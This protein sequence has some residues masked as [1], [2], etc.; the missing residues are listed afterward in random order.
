MVPRNKE[1]EI[2]EAFEEAE[3][4]HHHMMHILH[5][6]LRF[7][8]LM[9][10]ALGLFS[11]AGLVWT[12]GLMTIVHSTPTAVKNDSSRYTCSFLTDLTMYGSGYA[13]MALSVFEPV[14]SGVTRR[15]FRNLLVVDMLVNPFF[16]LVYAYLASQVFWFL[17]LRGGIF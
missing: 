9:I 15:C 6:G 5:G 17:F 1:N 11:L 12:E 10:V 4:S 14:V 7:N 3:N 8:R 2:E 13:A 16:I